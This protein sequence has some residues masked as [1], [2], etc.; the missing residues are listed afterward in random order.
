MAAGCRCIESTQD[1]VAVLPVSPVAFTVHKN[2]AVGAAS[3]A[4][5]TRF[6]GLVHNTSAE[7]RETSNTGDLK[8]RFYRAKLRVARY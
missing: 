2:V 3:F 1:E 7:L 5:G 6:H 8:K 4:D